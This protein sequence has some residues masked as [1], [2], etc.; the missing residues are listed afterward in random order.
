MRT[1][2]IHKYK[3]TSAHDTIIYG[4][5]VGFSGWLGFPNGHNIW[6]W[7]VELYGVFRNASMQSDD[8]SIEEDSFR[9]VQISRVTKDWLV[10]KMSTD[11]FLKHLFITVEN[12]QRWSRKDKHKNCLTSEA[13]QGFDQ[14]DRNWFDMK[15]SSLPYNTINLCTLG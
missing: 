8:R 1:H 10:Q 2:P 4:L 15:R 3:S 7:N 6:S 13:N 11:D 9:G 5:Y 14:Q 12:A